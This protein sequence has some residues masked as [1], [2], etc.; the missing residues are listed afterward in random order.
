VAYVEG[1]D[2]DGKKQSYWCAVGAV[3]PHENGEGF[4]VVIHDQIS[5]SGR[6]MLRGKNRPRPGG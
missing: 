3:W 1:G 5:A 2:Q 6:I 4:D